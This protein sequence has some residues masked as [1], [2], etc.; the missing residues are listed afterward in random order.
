MSS[1]R[2]TAVAWPTLCFSPRVGGAAQAA[3]DQHVP[4]LQGRPTRVLYPH[5]HLAGAVVVELLPWEYPNLTFYVALGA[6]PLRHLVF[7]V[8]GADAYKA[9]QV[10]VPTLVGAMQREIPWKE[11]LTTTNPGRP[12]LNKASVLR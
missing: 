1:W 4:P 11:L 6:L 5:P 7:P 10:D 8:E 2:R 3:A 12:P 9:M